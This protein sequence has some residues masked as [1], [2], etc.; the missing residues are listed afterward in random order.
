MTKRLS[1]ACAVLAA[2]GMASEAAGQER[3]FSGMYVGTEAGANNVIAGADING[4]DTLAQERR[5]GVGGFVGAR[6]QLESGVVLGAEAGAAWEDGNLELRQTGLSIDYE[7]NLRWR[8]GA[9][10][11]IAVGERRDTLLYA[12]F[13]EMKRSFDVSIQQ[14]PSAFQQQD[15]QGLFVLGV[16]VERAFGEHFSVRGSLG[17]ARP[18]F[19]DRQLNMRPETIVDFNIAALWRF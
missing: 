3:R 13:S 10:V 16:G 12:Y 19:G 11:G 14:G 6:I 4:V 2:L 8:Y 5:L 9:T 7:N 15:E 17:G 1:A 18:D